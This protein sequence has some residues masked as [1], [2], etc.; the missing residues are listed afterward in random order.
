MVDK[1]DIDVE[2]K[3]WWLDQPR[4]CFKT[5][6]KVEAK[7]TQN[8]FEVYEIDDGTYAIY[9]PGHFQEVISYLVIGEEK[10]QKVS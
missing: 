10:A 6:K 8:W 2:Q 9:E 3:E 4:S 1:L 7:N 5:L